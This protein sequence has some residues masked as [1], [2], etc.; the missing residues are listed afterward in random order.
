MSCEIEQATAE[1]SN[2]PRVQVGIAHGIAIVDGTSRP[3]VT[4]I[5]RELGGTKV[6]GCAV[7]PELRDISKLTEMLYHAAFH[8]FPEPMVHELV[9]MRTAIDGT[10]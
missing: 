4:L 1:V 10:K 5:F 7:Y 3:I 2:A 6:L 8:A 9:R